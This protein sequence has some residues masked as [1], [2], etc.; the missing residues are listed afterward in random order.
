MTITYTVFDAKS[1]H[2]YGSGLT[3]DEA[4][5]C[6]R[7]NLTVID[8]EAEAEVQRDDPG[9]DLR[10]ISIRSIGVCTDAGWPIYRE[11]WRGVWATPGQK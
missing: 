9:S 4:E 3:M 11:L 7:D 6:Y 1:L 10:M 2:V 8:V 5:Q